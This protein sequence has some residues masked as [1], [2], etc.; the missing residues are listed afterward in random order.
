MSTPRRRRRGAAVL[1]LALLCCAGPRE[2]TALMAGAPPDSPALRQDP[3]TATSAWRGVGSLTVGAA[4]Y[5][6]VAITTRHVLTA[7]HVVGGIAPA[8]IRFVLNTGGS[9]VSLAAE[10]V[11]LFPSASF[12][13]DDLAVIRLSGDIPAPATPYPILTRAITT[14]QVITLVGY[15]ASGNGDTGVSVTSSA[16]VKR[17]GVN[18]VDAIRTTLDNSG[19]SSLFLLHDFDGPGGNGS[20]G[21]A[22]LG[23]AVETG[24]AGGDS[25]SPVFAW[26]D[27]VTW[28]VGISNFVTS[29]TSG[30]PVNYRFGTIGGGILLSDPR[31]LAWLKE[32][33]GNTLYTP[34][35]Q[36]EAEVPALP[37]WATGTLALGLAARIL[38]GRGNRP[39][40]G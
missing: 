29:P 22:T 8:Q 33:T 4:T 20:L 28:L 21:G 5:S 23:N 9:P 12:P 13:Y 18:V 36:S 40:G 1:V 10:A 30:V 14:G 2:A 39:G 6:A 19:R 32:T 3:N 26:V 34:P 15:G 38:R 35:A 11:T 17:W 7:A 25:G 16:S 37:L 24:L 31:F 27:G